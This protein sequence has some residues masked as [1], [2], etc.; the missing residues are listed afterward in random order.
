METLKLS[1][2]AWPA[3]SHR[4]GRATLRHRLPHLLRAGSLAA[5]L[6]AFTT[7]AS[8]Q[9]TAPEAKQKTQQAERPAYVIER[10]GRTDAASITRQEAMWSFF[11]L[12]SSM[13][14]KSPGEARSLL[15]EHGAGLDGAAADK[16]IAH[17]SESMREQQQYVRS[18][19]ASECS[20]L[21]QKSMS[22]E[23]V[24]ARL[25]EI[26]A[27]EQVHRE[28]LV[29]RMFTVLEPQARHK[30]NAWIDTNV[31]PQTQIIDFDYPMMLKETG[32][33]GATLLARLCKQSTK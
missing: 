20:N 2:S 26:D 6:G 30:L 10:N 16:V 28:G 4:S 9:E 11:I 18:A 8:A 15:L 1:L 33:D 14:S 5:L 31:R 23:A 21:R 13:E 22:T 3:G 7:I 27:S 32:I 24:V 17:I 25:I 29:D 12:V 19:S